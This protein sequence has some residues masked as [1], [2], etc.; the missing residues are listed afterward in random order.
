M[1]DDSPLTDDTSI[2]LSTGF[3]KPYKYK[4]LAY[5]EWDNSQ[6]SL[7]ELRKRHQRGEIMMQGGQTR[8]PATYDG[9]MD[10]SSLNMNYNYMAVSLNDAGCGSQ[11]ELRFSRA[12]NT[13]VWV[14]RARRDMTFCA[15]GGEQLGAGADPIKTTSTL[16]VFDFF[17]DTYV[18]REVTVSRPGCFAGET[19]ETDQ[20]TDRT[21][22]I[23]DL[24]IEVGLDVGDPYNRRHRIHQ[25]GE[26]TQSGGYDEHRTDN[27]G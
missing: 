25:V 2:Y 7:L 15:Y 17:S 5:E 23:Y 16:S 21:W 20:P 27:M 10:S 8:A 6:I 11:K 19:G 24:N 22:A 26:Y 9:F 18:D 4:G 14:V 12:I 1:V 13:G 3:R